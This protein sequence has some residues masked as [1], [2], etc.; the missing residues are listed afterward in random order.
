MSQAPSVTFAMTVA[1]R[2]CSGS[3]VEWNETPA[4]EPTRTT[5]GP[6]AAS[7]KPSP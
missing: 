2:S 1:V 6:E 7:Q 4:S 5:P 3:W